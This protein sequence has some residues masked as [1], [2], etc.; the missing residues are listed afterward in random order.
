MNGSHCYDYCY[1]S[2]GPAEI[3][4]F[5]LRQETDRGR[6]RLQQPAAP[7][8]NDCSQF[9]QGNA[10]ISRPRF[11]ASCRYAAVVALTLSFAFTPGNLFAQGNAEGGTSS[12]TG[13]EGPLFQ[14][15]E[16]DLSVFD[17]VERSASIGTSTT[18]G[19]GIAAES[20]GGTTGRG[21]GGGG[22]GGGGFGGGLGGLGGLFG[23][24]GGAFGGQGAT[25]Q[26]PIIRVR[27][28]S[29]IEVAPRPAEQ[30]Q[31]SVIDTL[32][33][34]PSR[35]GL[36]KVGVQVEGRTAILFGTVRTEKDRRMSELMMRLEPGI[37]RV[38]NR[39]TVEN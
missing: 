15:T 34:L 35:N 18:Q 16:P 31:Q 36:E 1:D 3:G 39:V 19:F 37:D 24:L 13:G 4:E 6:V 25:N 17:G 22:G 20:A 32:N 12:V 23:G 21:G 27:L 10:M 8:P 26:R 11:V 9:D 14:A 33:I 28:R 30:V 5:W 38:D 7:T 29:A 2:S